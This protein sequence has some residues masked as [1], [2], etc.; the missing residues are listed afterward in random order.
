MSR[1]ALASFTLGAL[2]GLPSLALATT[3]PPTAVDSRATAMG[4]TAVAHV[5]NGAAVYHNAAALHEVETLTLSATLAMSRI[6]QTAPG[7]GE[8]DPST[9]PL[10]LIGGGYRLS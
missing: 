4:S 5:H 9:I 8:S 1:R 7:L 10:F 6:T 3:E 2:T